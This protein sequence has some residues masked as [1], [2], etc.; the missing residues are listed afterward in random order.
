MF[1]SAQWPSSV[2]QLSAASIA[3]E[4]GSSACV[5]V[6]PP[7]LPSG[8]SNALNGEA[9]VPTLSLLT[10]LVKPE[11]PSLLPIRLLP[12][13][14]NAL[15]TSGDE[16]A[17]LPAIIVFLTFTVLPEAST[18]PPVPEELPDTVLLRIVRVLIYAMMPPAR[19]VELELPEIVLLITVAVLPPMKMPPPNPLTELLEIVLLMIFRLP[20]ERLPIPPPWLLVPLAVLPEIVLFAIVSVP[21]F[22]MPPPVVEGV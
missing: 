11:L 10:P 6:A 9:T 14:L 22:R 8:A 21:L 2:T 1:A 15:D 3:G 12:C 7:L 16:G 5:C 17:V 18:P 20:P 4:P 19:P 13:E